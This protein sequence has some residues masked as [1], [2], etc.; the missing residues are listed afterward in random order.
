[1][2]VL[3]HTR[4]LRFSLKHKLN[5]GINPSRTSRPSRNL[6]RKQSW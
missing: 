1:M 3:I 5:A 2:L 4:S 6:Y